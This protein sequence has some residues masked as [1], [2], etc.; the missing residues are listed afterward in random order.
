LVDAHDAVVN[1]LDAPVLGPVSAI[2]LRKAESLHGRPSKPYDRRTR[3]EGAAMLA[4]RAKGKRFLDYRG[5]QL[6]RGAALAKK[7]QA[8]DG[9]PI[10]GPALEALNAACAALSDLG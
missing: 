1:A 2:G 5:S 10:D 7:A 9:A 4:A 6:G 8:A 3:F